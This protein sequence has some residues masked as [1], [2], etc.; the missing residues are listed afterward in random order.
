MVVSLWVK[1]PFRSWVLGG[2]RGALFDCLIWYGTSRLGI[3][4]AQVIGPSTIKYS[5]WY[6]TQ[7]RAS[8]PS[9][10]VCRTREPLL[11]DHISP[12]PIFSNKLLGERWKMLMSCLSQEDSLL[13]RSSWSREGGNVLCF[14]LNQSQG[15]FPYCQTGSGEAGSV[16]WFRHYS[17]AILNEL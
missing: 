10:E 2:V 9:M 5:Q 12:E 6:H 8:V 15:E 14:W 17:F 16:S 7:C 3:I 13:T 4:M 11:L 1:L